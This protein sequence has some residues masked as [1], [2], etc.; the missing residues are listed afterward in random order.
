MKVCIK[1]LFSYSVLLIY[2][3]AFSIQENKLSFKLI[4]ISA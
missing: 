4:E 2:R 3:D 1:W